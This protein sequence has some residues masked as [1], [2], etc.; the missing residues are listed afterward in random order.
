MIRWLILFVVLLTMG[1]VAE[2]A[3]HV[4]PQIDGEWWSVTGNPDLG[5]Y[6]SDQQ[7]PVDFG[8]HPG[9]LRSPQFTPRSLIIAKHY[10]HPRQFHSHPRDIGL[11]VKNHAQKDRGI[12]GTRKFVRQHQGKSEARLRPQIDLG[13]LG[14]RSIYLFCH[15][16][17]PAHSGIVGQL[18]K[19]GRCEIA[20]NTII[21]RL[22]EGNCWRRQHQKRESIERAG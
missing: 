19:L 14:E 18:K 12:G 5:R 22:G 20:R 6:T 16:K 1:R 15:V 11:F 13:V 2:A 9:R 21:A 4:I 17:L 3:D 7:Q 8:G 10:L